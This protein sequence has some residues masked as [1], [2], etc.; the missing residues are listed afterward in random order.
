V[1]PARRTPI[2]SSRFRVCAI[3]YADCIRI[4]VY[5][6]TPSAF[7]IRSEGYTQEQV[8]AYAKSIE[9]QTLDPSLPSQR[10]EDWLQSGPPHAHIGYWRVSDTCD[11]KELEVPFPNGDWPIL[12]KGLMRAGSVHEK[13][14]AGVGHRP[15]RLLIAADARICER[16][17]RGSVCLWGQ[18]CVDIGD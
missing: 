11:L 1:H 13:A 5:L 8:I 14:V 6:F 3:S 18:S 17:R 15:H 4:R 2:N 16:P 10:L 12:R 9:V 7:S